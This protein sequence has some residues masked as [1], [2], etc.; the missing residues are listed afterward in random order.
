[1]PSHAAYAGGC[2]TLFFS[3]FVSSAGGI[4]G[5]G[6][7]VPILLLIFGYSFDTAVAL[8]LCVVLGNAFAQFLLNIQH[9]NPFN[10]RNP[11]IWPELMIVLSPAQFGGS[12]FGSYLAKIFP[13][14]VMYILALCILVFAIKLTIEKGR[15]KQKEETENPYPGQLTSVEDLEQAKRLEQTVHVS[16]PWL[17]IGMLFLTWVAYLACSIGRSQLPACSDG[18]IAMFLVAYIPLTMGTLWGMWHNRN[19]LIAREIAGEEDDNNTLLTTNPMP[20][21]EDV[22]FTE[23]FFFLPVLTF[24]IGIVC[25]LLGI[26]GGELLSP[27]L[28]SYHVPPIITSATSAAMSLLNTLALVIRGFVDGS[29]SFDSG[30]VLFLMGFSGGLSGRKAGLYFAHTYHKASVI[31]FALAGALALSALYYVYKLS[32]EEFETDLSTAC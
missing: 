22:L 23:N 20:A 5:G 8:S 16:W 29:L 4:G 10:K 11:L 32:S 30:I 19:R 26:G 2:V 6:L 1:M 14:S 7:S 18:Y 13:D 31:I 28:L 3:S 27:M 25:S 17:V 12:N 9:S 15:Q 24:C 21:L